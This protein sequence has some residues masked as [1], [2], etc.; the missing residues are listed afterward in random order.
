MTFKLNRVRP[1]T[2]IFE[3]LFKNYLN[4]HHDET[5]YRAQHLGRY[6]KG[7]GHSMTFKQNSFRPITFLFEVE[8]YNYLQEWSPYWDNVSRATFGLLPWR[9]RSQHDLATKSCLAQNFVIW[10]RILQL[11]LTNY[12]SVSKTYSGSITRFR[13]VLVLLANNVL[14]ILPWKLFRVRGPSAGGND[15]NFLFITIVYFIVNKYTGE[16]FSMA[17]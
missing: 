13:P 3:V 6:L 17:L 4:D 12:F 11:L 7:Q 8:F 10:S 2:S 9:P 14:V 16:L 1:I 15:F 5:T